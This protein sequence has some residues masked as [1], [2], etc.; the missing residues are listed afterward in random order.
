MQLNSAVL[1]EEENMTK[2]TKKTIN[3]EDNRNFVSSYNGLMINLPED[4]NHYPKIL[5]D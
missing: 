1:F 2:P 3:W 4:C 5:L